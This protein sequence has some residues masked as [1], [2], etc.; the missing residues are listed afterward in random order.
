[1]DF[2]VSVQHLPA[3]GET[4]LGNNFKMLP[5]GKGA[6]QACAAGSLAGPNT[7]VRMIGRV[8]HD[9][10]GDHL[11]A[12]LSAAGVDVSFGARLA[13]ATDRR[14]SYSGGTSG[15]NSIIVASGANMDLPVAD[16]EAM[17]QVFRGARSPSSN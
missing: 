12:S 8:G 2:V 6:N 15:Q 14:G 10:F 16:V 11:K 4:V 1:M 5:G 13:F 3:P 7:R 9:V 17:R